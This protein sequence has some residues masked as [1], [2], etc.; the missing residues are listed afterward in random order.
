MIDR[1]DSTVR[2]PVGKPYFDE[3]YEPLG[4][5]LVD[6]AIAQPLADGMDGGKREEK[7]MPADPTWVFVF[8]IVLTC[9]MEYA[10]WRMRFPGLE[11][12]CACPAQAPPIP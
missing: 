3:R 5:D 1:I 12:C 2:K 4:S 7:F 11:A 6:N 8:M 10:Q 9:T